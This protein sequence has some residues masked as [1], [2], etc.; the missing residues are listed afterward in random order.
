MEVNPYQ[1]PAEAA[2]E[3]V[4]QEPATRK[5]RGPT[6]GLIL[7]SGMSLIGCLLGV[8]ALPVTVLEKAYLLGVI[9]YQNIGLAV[10]EFFL[11]LPNSVILY[12]AYQARKGKAYRWAMAAAILGCI[13]ILSPGLYFGIPLGIWM[14]IVLRRTDVRACFATKIDLSHS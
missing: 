8:L 10:L 1:S 6:M 13:P 14:L 12:G 11:I 3:P 4:A 2:S 7:L 5:L 9:D